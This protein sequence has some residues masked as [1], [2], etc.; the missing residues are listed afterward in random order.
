MTCISTAALAAFLSLID[1]P[2]TSTATGLTVHAETGPVDYL[3]TKRGWCWG[4]L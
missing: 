2:V 1:V 4:A 3:R